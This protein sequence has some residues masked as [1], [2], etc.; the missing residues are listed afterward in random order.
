MF[1]LKASDGTNNLC[2]KNIVKFRM[3][4]DPPLSQRK[5]AQMLQVR[6]Y[7]VD[8]HF[9]RRLELGERFVTDIELAMLAEVLNVSYEDLLSKE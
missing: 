4:H 5:F 9:V 6:G 2:G 1:K 7:D 8:H 3:S